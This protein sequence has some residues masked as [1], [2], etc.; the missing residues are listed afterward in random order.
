MPEALYGYVP[1]AGFYGGVN[2]KKELGTHQASF[3]CDLTAY[4]ERGANS[5]CAFSSRPSELQ[6]KLPVLF[7]LHFEAVHRINHHIS[8]ALCLAVATPFARSVA[9]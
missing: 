2:E 6:L 7:S 3:K 1:R 5:A 8:A 9:S 4:I